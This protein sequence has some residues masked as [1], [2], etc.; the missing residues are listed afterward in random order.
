MTDALERSKLCLRCDEAKPLSDFYETPQGVHGRMPYCKKCDNSRPRKVTP[1]RIARQRARQRATADLIKL[2]PT[3]FAEL[4]ERH[5]VA[6]QDEM[7]ILRLQPEAEQFGDEV[8]RL[9]PGQAM[10]GETVEDR[11][12]EPACSSCKE[13]HVKGH[14]CTACGVRPAP[15]GV[16]A[17]TVGVD[18]VELERF[19]AGT[20][21]AREAAS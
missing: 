20:R 17:R 18:L 13:A 15:S 11:I 1:G 21:R 5:T 10:P 12:A 4:L 9:K 8:V 14:K 7:E 16:R 3:E 6:V 2:H 19:N